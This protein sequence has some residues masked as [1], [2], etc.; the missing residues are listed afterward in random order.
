MTLVHVGDSRAYL[1][2]EGRLRQITEDHSWVAEMIRRGELTP[3]QAAIHP[4]R[5]VITRRSAPSGEIQPDLVEMELRLRGD[6]LLLCSD[7]LTGMVADTEIEQALSG[8]GQPQ[9]T[10]EML[11]TAALA[12]GG[13]DNVTVVVV[14]VTPTPT[15]TTPQAIADVAEPDRA[16]RQPG[17]R[18]HRSASP[19]ACGER[20]ERRETARRP[21][22]TPGRRSWMTTRSP[23]TASP[24]A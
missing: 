17:S 18:P 13:E 12:A 4:H 9:E 19:P 1:L 2:H 20:F 7:G 6:R 8:T 15:G 23:R 5:S 24:G 21:D 16:P 11:V 10:A 3:A 14:D 22:A